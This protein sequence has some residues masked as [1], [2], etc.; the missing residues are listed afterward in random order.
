[1]LVKTYE[2]KIIQ[3]YPGTI[4]SDWDLNE[5]GK[6]GFKIGAHVDS[7]TIIYDDAG[8]AVV[9]PN[10]TQLIMEKEKEI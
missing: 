5:L 2:Y 10:G 3:I 1:M 8:I 6:E 4:L 9:T 7:S